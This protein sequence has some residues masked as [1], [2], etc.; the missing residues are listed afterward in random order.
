[1][2]TSDRRRLAEESE[3]LRRDSADAEL[4]AL[5]AAIYLEDAFDIVLPASLLDH[6]HLGS[7][8]ALARTLSGIRGDA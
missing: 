8:A 5:V 2:G 4:D 1:M 6:E 3:R 7:P